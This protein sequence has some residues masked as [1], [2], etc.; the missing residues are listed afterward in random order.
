MG[1]PVA[2]VD[3]IASTVDDAIKIR[4]AHDA[5]DTAQPMEKALSLKWRPLE[6]KA[7]WGAYFFCVFF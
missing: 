6:V 7:I 3:N 4:R 1:T 2:A 5:P